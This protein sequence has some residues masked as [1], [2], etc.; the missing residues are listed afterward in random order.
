MADYRKSVYLGSGDDGKRLSGII[1]K[2]GKS[3]QFR[4]EMEFMRHCIT[5]TLD[6]DPDVRKIK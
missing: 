2:M 1:E 3:E 4:S 5:Y 6:H